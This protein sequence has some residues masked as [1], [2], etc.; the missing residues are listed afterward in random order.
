M[1]ENYELLLRFAGALRGRGV[2]IT[3]RGETAGVLAYKYLRLLMV[4]ART[5]ISD[6]L[7]AT[8]KERQNN[9]C[10]ACGDLLR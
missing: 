7:T 1:P 3:Y 5:T 2:N 9:R 10:G 4:R 6:E 8:L